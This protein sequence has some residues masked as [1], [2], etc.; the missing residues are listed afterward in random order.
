MEEITSDPNFKNALTIVEIIFKSV[1][2]N[3][4]SPTKTPTNND[5]TV[6][7]VINANIM[8]TRGGN[9][10]KIPNRVEFSVL[11]GVWEIHN[12]KTKRIIIVIAV[13]KPIF[14]L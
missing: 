9:N 3:M 6:S 8:A 4:N 2:H 13:I 7:F 14:I 10:V 1:T 5:K 12:D 11:V